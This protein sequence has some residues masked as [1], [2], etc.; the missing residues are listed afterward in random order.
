MLENSGEATSAQFKS[1]GAAQFKWCRSPDPQVS[2]TEV[3]PR[4]ALGGFRRFREKLFLL[5][6]DLALDLGHEPQSWPR[7]HL[8]RMRVNFGWNYW[9]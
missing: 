5:A 7:M 1:V 2:R 4:R 6:L 9:Q 3:V 8:N